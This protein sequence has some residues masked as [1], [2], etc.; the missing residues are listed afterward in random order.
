MPTHLIVTDG[1]HGGARGG[2]SQRAHTHTQTQNTQKHC[3]HAVA[4]LFT[5][6]L[7]ESRVEQNRRFVQRFETFSFSPSYH[8]CCTFGA[9]LIS[10]PYLMRLASS[11]AENIVF[12]ELKE[13]KLR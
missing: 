10:V 4:D 9:Q 12:Y 8:N 2:L 11:L 5:A 6:T 7:A 3:I 1:G 13:F